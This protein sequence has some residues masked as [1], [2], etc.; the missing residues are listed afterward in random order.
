MSKN[1]YRDSFIIIIVYDISSKE[2][3]QN[4]KDIW[5]PEINLFGEKINIVVLVGNK[6]DKYWGE[7]VF[8]EEKMIYTK[9][10]YANFFQFLLIVKSALI[11]CFTI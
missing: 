3:F 7:E 6:K 11:I 8:Y 4:I 9:E 5:Y 1:F 10:I 2:S